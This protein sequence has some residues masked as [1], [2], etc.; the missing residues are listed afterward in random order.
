MRFERPCNI[1]SVMTQI[2]IK[3]YAVICLMEQVGQKIGATLCPTGAGGGDRNAQHV[4]KHCAK[5][6]DGIGKPGKLKCNANVMSHVY[7]AQ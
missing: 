1:S 4:R 6:S 2:S 3:S 7:L 5:D